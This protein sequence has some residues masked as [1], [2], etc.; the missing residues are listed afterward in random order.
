MD[1]EGWQEQA[2]AALRKWARAHFY[3]AHPH[4]YTMEKI[5][6]CRPFAKLEAPADLRWFGPVVQRAIRECIIVRVGFAPAKS[7]HGGMKARYAGTRHA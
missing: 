7:S 1:K 6:E 3:G 5:R 2:Y 4:S